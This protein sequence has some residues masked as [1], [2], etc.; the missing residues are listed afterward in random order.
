MSTTYTKKLK[1]DYSIALEKNKGQAEVYH[2]VSPQGIIPRN[3]DLASDYVFC[4]IKHKDN[5]PKANVIKEY[6]LAAFLIK[7]ALESESW[8]LP[9]RGK[10]WKLLDSERTFAKPDLSDKGKG[11]RLDILA[12]EEKTNSYIVLELKV[13][14]DFS[15]ANKELE[16]YTDTIKK[17]IEAVNEFYS[18]D[19]NNVKGYIVWNATERT[20]RKIENKWGIIEYDIDVLNK[21]VDKLEFSI[22]TE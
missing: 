7:K 19:A 4:D 5:M 22:I 12:Y 20:R 9:I 17:Q 6:K 10:E 16:C 14:R 13:E 8:L 21:D 11:K 3:L 18:V 1:D 15:K 2:C